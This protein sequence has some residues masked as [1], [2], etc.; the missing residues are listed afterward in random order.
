MLLIFALIAIVAIAV[1]MSRISKTLARIE[2]HLAPKQPR[3]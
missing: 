2:Q 3:E 1:E